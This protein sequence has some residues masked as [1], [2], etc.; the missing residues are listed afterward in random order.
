MPGEAPGGALTVVEER[1]DRG[2]RRDIGNG[3]EG[4]FGPPHDQQV[5]VGEGD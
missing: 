4:A 5:V 1:V 2:R 3:G